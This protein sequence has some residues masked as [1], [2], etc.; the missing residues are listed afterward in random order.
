MPSKHGFCFPKNGAFRWKSVLPHTKND[1]LGLHQPT[2]QDVVVLTGWRRPRGLR[3]R[4]ESRVSAPRSGVGVG[5]DFQCWSATRDFSSSFN[6]ASTVERTE[7]F[8]FLTAADLKKVLWFHAS[9]FCNIHAAD[10]SGNSRPGVVWPED[11]ADVNGRFQDRSWSAV[12]SVPQCYHQL[13]K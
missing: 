8:V 13:I 10:T 9:C 11:A 1:I 4:N 7:R 2:N 3:A 5:L 6:L 12:F